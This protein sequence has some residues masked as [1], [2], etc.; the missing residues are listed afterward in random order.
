[1]DCAEDFYGEFPDIIVASG[2]SARSLKPD[3][4]FRKE[5]FAIHQ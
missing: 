5:V 1:M 4:P 2:L 3:N